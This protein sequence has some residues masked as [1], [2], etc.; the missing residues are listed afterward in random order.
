M[1]TCYISDEVPDK[2]VPIR[3]GTNENIPQNVTASAP[4][5]KRIGT[6]ADKQ[7]NSVAKVESENGEPKKTDVSTLSIKKIPTFA[8]N[9]LNR[10][11]ST[12][13]YPKPDPKTTTFPP[14]E[15]RRPSLTV[16]GTGY[17]EAD[18]WEKAEMVKINER[19]FIHPAYIKVLQQSDEYNTCMFFV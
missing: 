18:A 10:S 15:I 3:E 19:Y 13:P 12:N 1:I 4:S 8:D 5:F 7:F 9:N 17:T 11:A 6:T 16:P 2:K 14:A